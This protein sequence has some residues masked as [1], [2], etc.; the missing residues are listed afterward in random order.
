MP[1]YVFPCCRDSINAWLCILMK[2]QALFTLNNGRNNFQVWIWRRA[3]PK[4]RNF[5]GGEGRLFCDQVKGAVHRHAIEYTIFCSN[6][7]ASLFKI[8]RQFPLA[9]NL[10]KIK[11][12]PNEIKNLIK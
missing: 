2:S 7:Y 5:V 4:Y 3:F 6:S 9:K 11:A 8:K 1:S 12:E 10:S